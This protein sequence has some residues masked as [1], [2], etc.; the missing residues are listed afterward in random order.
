MVDYT[1][2]MD[3]V[4]F[5]EITGEIKYFT[6]EEIL[7]ISN[8]IEIPNDD[9]DEPNESYPTLINTVITRYDIPYRKTREDYIEL[10]DEEY[11][12]LLDGKVANKLKRW[13]KYKDLTAVYPHDIFRYHPGLNKFK[14]REDS[15]NKKIEHIYA[16]CILNKRIKHQNDDDL[17]YIKIQEYINKIIDALTEREQLLIRYLYYEMLP[18]DKVIDLMGFKNK[19][20]LDT[21]KSDCL[22][23]IKRRLLKEY[24]YILEEYNGTRLL[25]WTKKIKQNY[26]YK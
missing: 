26:K 23:K 6:D 2:E 8:E 19:K 4:N 7:L 12:N 18:S 13:H 24:E 10:N 14:L 25:Y 16:K 3:A 20:A 15:T 5:E 21:E 1:R 22:G 11:S 17:D 9:E